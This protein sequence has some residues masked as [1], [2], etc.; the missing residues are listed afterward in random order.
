MI[1]RTWEIEDANGK[2]RVTLA[3]YRAELD[4]RKPYAKAIADAVRRGDLDGSAKAQAA[5]R[6]KFR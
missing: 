6:A 2:R 4:A 3:E 5:M 1:E